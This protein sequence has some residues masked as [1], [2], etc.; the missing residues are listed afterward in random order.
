MDLAILEVAKNAEAAR[1]EAF[2]TQQEIRQLRVD[3]AN[4]AG[5]VLAPKAR[6]AAGKRAVEM[7]KHELR[8]GVPAEEAFQHVLDS[9]F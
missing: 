5:R 8:Q 4:F 9:D 6:D 7:Y 1:A 2:S 3:L